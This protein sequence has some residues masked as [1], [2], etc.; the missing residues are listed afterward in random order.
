MKYIFIAL[1]AASSIF[2]SSCARP[3]DDSAARV[4]PNPATQNS[5]HEVATADP[6]NP[7]PSQENSQIQNQ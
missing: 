6:V 1:L 4:S 5:K 3:S 7:D 2:D